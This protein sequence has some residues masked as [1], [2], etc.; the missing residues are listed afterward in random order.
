MLTVAELS[1]MQR[2]AEAEY[3]LECC[4]VVLEGPAGR[5]VVRC[6][7]LS[8][9]HI[10][11]LLDPRGFVADLRTGARVAAIYHSHPDNGGAVLSETDRR[12]ALLHD[13]K[14]AYPEALYVVLSVL[15]GRV[16]AAASFRWN[17]QQ[18]DFLPVAA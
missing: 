5:R 13:G 18:R 14:P 17:P 6:R 4:G 10:G 7:N 15:Q 1:E 11:Y 16:D 3:P 2:H 12:A 9:S 8:R